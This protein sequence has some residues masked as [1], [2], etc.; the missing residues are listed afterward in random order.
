MYGK[1]LAF[2]CIFCAYSISFLGEDAVTFKEKR[3]KK[4]TE[5]DIQNLYKKNHKILFWDLTD[6]KETWT[7][8]KA[9]HF[10]E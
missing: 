3:K 1:S 9:V 6:T 10:L 5:Q 7:S 8:R 2:C 4:K